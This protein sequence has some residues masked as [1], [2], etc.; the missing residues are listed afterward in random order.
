MDKMSLIG[1]LV[2]L[3]LFTGIFFFFV[4]PVLQTTL[5]KLGAL[6]G[7]VVLMVIFGFMA[8]KVLK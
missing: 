2:V 1:F 5:G 6:I 8:L 4:A 3:L 7:A